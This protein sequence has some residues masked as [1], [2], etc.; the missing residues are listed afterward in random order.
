MCSCPD[1]AI[2][3]FGNCWR[4]AKLN[5]CF[6]LSISQGRR[7]CSDIYIYLFYFFS[8]LS[9]GICLRILM[10]GL[11]PEITIARTGTVW[12]IKWYSD[13]RTRNRALLM[14]ESVQLSAPMPSNR[15]PREASQMAHWRLRRGTWNGYSASPNPMFCFFNGTPHQSLIQPTNSSLNIPILASSKWRGWRRLK[16]GFKTGDDC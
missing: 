11:W 9:G 16:S 2:V 8:Q 6:T 15:I 14:G 10:V 4:K 1:V 12:F 3:Q 7:T 5:V 13:D